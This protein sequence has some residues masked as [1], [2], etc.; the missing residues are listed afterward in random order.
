[1]HLAF[2]VRVNP[3]AEPRDI[4]GAAQRHA[5]DVMRTE[6]WE[7]RGAARG[8]TA[9]VICVVLRGVQKALCAAAAGNVFIHVAAAPAGCEGAGAAAVVQHY[10]A[11]LFYYCFAAAAAFKP[12]ARVGA[13]LCFYICTVQRF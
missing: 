10:R 7:G 13:Y 6:G 3:V 9:G 11:S 12:E 2:P 1:M 8:H 4:A 5:A